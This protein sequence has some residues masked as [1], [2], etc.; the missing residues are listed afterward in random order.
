M[1]S[2]CIYWKNKITSKNHTIYINIKS[3]YI[4]ELNLAFHSRN[5]TFWHLLLLHIITVVT[6]TQSFHLHS[7]IY[8]SYG[9]EVAQWPHGSP[10]TPTGFTYN[11][12]SDYDP[13]C[14]NW[15]S[16]FNT[17]PRITNF[18]TAAN[19]SF[20][21]KQTQPCL[22]QFRERLK[23]EGRV[24]RFGLLKEM[25]L[26]VS[27]QR[28]ELLQHAQLRSSSNFSRPAEP[29]QTAGR[30]VGYDSRS[31]QRRREDRQPYLFMPACPPSDLRARR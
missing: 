15:Q 1:W 31:T 18:T 17:Q 2:Y 4:N 26:M 5:A 20:H 24:G 11:A 22:A 23:G 9:R 30:A 8:H 10:W 27:G 19:H 3:K 16:T 25:S 7:L 28:G 6:E 21:L 29:S 12:A 14:S 13:L